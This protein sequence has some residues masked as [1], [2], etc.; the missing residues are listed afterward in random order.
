KAESCKSCPHAEMVAEV[1]ELIKTLRHFLGKERFAASVFM[2]DQ[3]DKIRQSGIDKRLAAKRVANS[4]A[5]GAE[6][7]LEGVQNPTMSCYRAL[8]LEVLENLQDAETPAE[9][10][11]PTLVED[12]NCHACEICT[13]MCP[14]KALELCIP[15]YSESP[16]FEGQVLAHN[17]S[18]CT[19]C[20]LCY[21]SCP[22]ENLGGWDDLTTSDSPAYNTYPLTVKLCEKCGRPFK[23]EHDDDTLCPVCGR[24][25]M[26]FT[27]GTRTSAK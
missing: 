26:G 6:V 8:L 7:A 13:K 1:K 10:T 24:P 5:Q 20:G 27:P 3:P 4:V 11:W 17:A 22:H 2:H 23:P 19:Q 14:H 25:K 12:G 16:S 21:V 18:K 9:V 15:G